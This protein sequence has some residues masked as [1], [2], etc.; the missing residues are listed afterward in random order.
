MTWDRWRLNDVPMH[1]A[2]EKGAEF[3][4][5]RKDTDASFCI[6]SPSKQ[7]FYNIFNSRI[8]PV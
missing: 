2:L 6:Y 1:P 5:G 3:F 7:G 8:E 4:A